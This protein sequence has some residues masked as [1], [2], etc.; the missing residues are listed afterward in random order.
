MKLLIVSFFKLIRLILTPLV[1]AWEYMPIS[2]KVVR[3]PEEQQAVDA[4]TRN[5]VLY[6]FKT[7]PFCIKVRRA[8]RRLSLH[9]ET[10]DAQYDNDNRQALKQGG[11]EVQVPCLR[12][13]DENGNHRWLYESA[14]IIDYLEAQS[15]EQPLPPATS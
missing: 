6:D 12:I 10:R 8:T 13:T 2:N 7:C 1:L 11:G 14:L 3:S 4:K 5:L 15:I 9:I